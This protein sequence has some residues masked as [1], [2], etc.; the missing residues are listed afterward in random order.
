MV[1][2]RL[3]CQSTMVGTGRWWLLGLTVKV[4]W[5]GPADGWLLGLV[6]KAPWL[7]PADGWLLGL[8]VKVPWLGPGGAILA[9]AAWAGLENTTLTL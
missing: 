6:V 3:G 8:V 1:A 4:P 5:L 7:G 2:T 9:L